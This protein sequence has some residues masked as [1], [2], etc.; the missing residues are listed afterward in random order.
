[1][2]HG[3]YRILPNC[4]GVVLLLT[5]ISC[6][7]FLYRQLYFSCSFQSSVKSTF[8]KAMVL[9]ERAHRN[10]LVTVVSTESSSWYIQDRLKCAESQTHLVKDIADVSY[11]DL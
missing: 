3:T 9:G 8:V 4:P 6:L 7:K 1:M 10:V 2:S 11:F 5:R